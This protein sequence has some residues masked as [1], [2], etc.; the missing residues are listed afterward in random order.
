MNILK[1]KLYLSMEEAEK[2][3]TQV[4]RLQLYHH[5]V[6]VFP[7]D[8]SLCPARLGK[9]VNLEELHIGGCSDAQL[10]DEIQTLRQ[11]KT[12]VCLNTPIQALPD[13][14]FSC[15]SLRHLV[16][17]GSDVR[18]IPD[19]I[20]RLSELRHLD[21]GNNGLSAVPA[22]LGSL[23][24]LKTLDLPDNCLTDLPGEI[25][26]LSRLSALGLVNNAF[27]QQR[28]NEIRAWFRP[29]VVFL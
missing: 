16:V 10:P 25:A 29:G 1:P 8:Q 3:P 13:W 23:H 6:H 27:S 14:L 20:R 2:C 28:G 18:S 21:L 4:R 15:S 9:F 19:D 26:S 12:L 24:K 7:N 5:N 17:R 22:G 11:L